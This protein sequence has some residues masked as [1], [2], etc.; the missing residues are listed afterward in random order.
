MGDWIFFKSYH[1]INYSFT[2]SANNNWLLQVFLGRL[3]LSNEWLEYQLIETGKNYLKDASLAGLEVVDK[4]T[5]T[6]G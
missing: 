5:D 2:E 6:E 3:V 4:V 1:D